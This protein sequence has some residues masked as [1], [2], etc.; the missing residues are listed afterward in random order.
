M[1]NVVINQAGIQE[2]IRPEGPLLPVVRH[3]TERVVKKTQDNL[4]RDYPPSGPHG[5][6]PARRTGNLRQSVR[7][8]EPA[9][10]PERGFVIDVIA[11]AVNRYDGHPYAVNLRTSFSPPYVYITEAD[12]TSLIE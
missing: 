5:G 1:A 2:L 11:D 8:V 6:Y 7:Q 4:S 9:P 10:D 3:H 12:L